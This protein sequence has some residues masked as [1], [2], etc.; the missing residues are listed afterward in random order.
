VTAAQTLG[1]LMAS[2][3]MLYTMGMALDRAAENGYDVTLLVE[4]TWLSGR[5]AANDGTGVVVEGFE[6]E[7]CVIRTERIS[8]VKVLAAS[9]YQSITGA[10]PMPGT[11]VSPQPAYV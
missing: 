2:S 3:S 10:R 5:I 7:H 9:P 1:V 11:H 8:A 6:G 4:G